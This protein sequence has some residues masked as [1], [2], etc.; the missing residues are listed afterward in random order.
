MSVLKLKK[1]GV[2]HECVMY[3]AKPTTNAFALKKDGVTKYV[4]L[5]SQVQN[6][7]P[8][9]IGGLHLQKHAVKDIPTAPYVSEV[10]YGRVRLSSS[11]GSRIIFNDEDK[12][13]G[14]WFQHD[15]TEILDADANA[16]L[17]ADGDGLQS[18]LSDAKNIKILGRPSGNGSDGDELWRI[19]SNNDITV[20]K[21]ARSSLY[22]LRP[23]VWNSAYHSL[24]LYGGTVGPNTYA[25]IGK[26]GKGDG[27]DNDENYHG[28]Q[29]NGNTYVWF[30]ADGYYPSAL[31]RMKFNHKD[32]GIYDLKYDLDGLK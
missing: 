16:Y 1:D 4:A 20:N 10:G 18:P 17:P 8:I 22:T 5:S 13:S 28:S 12:E 30:S 14:E 7:T 24:Y 26:S 19:Y 2:V 31:A 32:Y 29:L 23:D 11:P 25:N 21:H 6:K 9:T 15:G 3:D 27:F